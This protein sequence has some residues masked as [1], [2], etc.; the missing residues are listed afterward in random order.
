MAEIIVPEDP[1]FSAARADPG[2]HRGVVFLVRQNEAIRQQ[3]ADRAKRRLIGHIAGR[4]GEG[5]LLSVQVGELH[6]ERDDGVA[7]AGDVRGAAGASPARGLDHGID[8]SGVASHPEI[9]VRAPD[10]DPARA[11]ATAPACIGWAV[12]APLE[13]GENA[14]A[15]LSTDFVEE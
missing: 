11:A 5:S 10:D 1:L 3:P 13:I 6:L 15:A 8:D 9:V 7:V 14:I 12:G 2:D 4:E